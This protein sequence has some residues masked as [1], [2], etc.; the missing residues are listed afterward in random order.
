[1]IQK[2]NFLAELTKLSL[3][4]HED[5]LSV[6]TYDRNFNNYVS[7]TFEKLS[8]TDLEYKNVINAL[9]SPQSTSNPERLFLLQTY[10]GEYSN[11]VSLL[12][13]LV[14]KGVSAIETLEKS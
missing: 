3:E 7:S 2:V 8:K 12:S 14:R 9:N 11:Y 1:M 10:L 13:T 5:N 6:N 4:G